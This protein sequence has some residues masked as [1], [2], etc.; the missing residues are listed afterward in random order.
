MYNFQ[1]FVMIN[2]FNIF[3]EIDLN[4]IPLDLIINKQHWF[5]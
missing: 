4:W 1:T 3:G 2:I 5:R